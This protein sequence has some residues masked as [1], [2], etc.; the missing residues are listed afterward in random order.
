[1]RYPH[2]KTINVVLSNSLSDILTLSKI[3]FFPITE[4]EF[5]RE[6]SI[7]GGERLDVIFLFQNCF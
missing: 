7:K 2:Q 5:G 6:Q 4:W 3:F 1:M